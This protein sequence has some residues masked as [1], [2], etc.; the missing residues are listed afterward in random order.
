MNCFNVSVSSTTKKRLDDLESEKQELEDLLSIAELKSPMISKEQIACF[1]Y[2]FR[3]LD[4]GQV[5]NRQIII[6]SFINSIYLYDDRLVMVYNY[7]DLTEAI[8]LKDL[9]ENIEQDNEPS[10]FVFDRVFG[11]MIYLNRKQ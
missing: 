1:V 5:K 4:P 10:T 6:D 9:E 7:N 11:Q 2:G 3:K 8:T